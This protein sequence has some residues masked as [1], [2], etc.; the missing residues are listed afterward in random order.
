MWCHEHRA[1][2]VTLFLQDYKCACRAEALPQEDSLPSQILFCALPF[3]VFLPFI[4]PWEPLPNKSLTLY[5]FIYTW[6]LLCAACEGLNE[7]DSISSPECSIL[8]CIV[9]C[10]RRRSVVGD[11]NESSISFTA[12]SSSNW[13]KENM[14]QNDVFRCLT[15][16]VSGF[17]VTT[18][19]AACHLSCRVVPPTCFELI[20][21]HILLYRS[22]LNCY[23]FIFQNRLFWQTEVSLEVLILNNMCLKLKSLLFVLFVLAVS[24]SLRPGCLMVLRRTAPPPQR[25]WLGR[26]LS[27][28][29]SLV[30]LHVRGMQNVERWSL[31]ICCIIVPII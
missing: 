17:M 30:F 15:K 2:S 3:K 19:K 16:E 22:H 11:E 12:K 25:S 29:P 27:R 28:Y 10:I 21:P 24:S 26:S 18:P 9:Y 5:V 23:R 8:Y 14:K 13:S 6:L 20:S 4:T 31:C 7:I 1:V